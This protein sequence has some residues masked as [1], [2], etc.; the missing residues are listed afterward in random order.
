MLFEEIHYFRWPSVTEYNYIENG[1]SHIFLHE[2]KVHSGHKIPDPQL[3]QLRFNSY[4][5]RR[6]M[7]RTCQTLMA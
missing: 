5:T 2:N 3:S 1:V 4:A 7:T 6:T